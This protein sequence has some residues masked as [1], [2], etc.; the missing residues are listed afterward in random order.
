MN[1]P[2][3]L[4]EALGAFL[5][6]LADMQPLALVYL[7]LIVSALVP[8]YAASHASLSCPSS[9]K[10]PERSKEK[11]EDDDEDDEDDED[12]KIHVM[13]GFRPSDAVLFPILAG[14]TLTVLYLLI[15]WGSTWLNVVL[16]VYFGILAIPAITQFLSDVFG[17]LIHLVFPRKYVSGEHLFLVLQEIRQ[18]RPV[19]RDGHRELH[20]SSPLPALLS[21][22]PL[23]SYLREL[24]W[25]IRGLLTMRLILR[26]KAARLFSFKLRFGIPEV[27]SSLITAA[28]LLYYNLVGK[29]WWITNIMGFAYS[30]SAL[31][32][33]SP[34]TFGTGT[35]ML[36]GLFIYDIYMV[37]YTYDTPPLSCASS[38][39]LT[40][41]GR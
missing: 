9:A 1:P 25:S 4:S 20:R 15:K 41:I 3:F 17:S 39:A 30:Y 40:S 34:S 28:L 10:K 35:L 13:E 2:S 22:L 12:L 18:A 7:H 38:T 6:A 27:S 33:M 36:A 8:I 26:V 37:F 21:K 11:T 24:L 14:I 32:I 19:A 5:F 16:N 31:R 23:G 29:A